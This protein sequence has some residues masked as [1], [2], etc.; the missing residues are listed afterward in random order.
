MKVFITGA[1]SGVGRALAEELVK[2]G[3]QVWGVARRGNLLAGIQQ[4]LN[5]GNFFYTQCDILSELDVK[6]VVAEM[7][8]RNFL[9]DTVVLNAGAFQE[10]I[11]PHYNH[12]IA[13]HIFA[14]NVYGALIWVDRLV[15]MFVKRGSGQFLAVSSTSAYRPDITSASYPASKVAL[16]MAFRSLRLR[17]QKENVFFKTI[18][19][20]PIATTISSRYTKFPEVQKKFFFVLTPKQA[21]RSLIKAMEG[22]KLEYYFPFS[23]LLFSV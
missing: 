23:S 15:A 4:E 1:S 11:S 10:D 17:Y 20:G 6:R 12:K 7:E 8:R 16:S 19:F 21:A 3:H 22:R 13:E 5:S 2:S 9:P 18:H 14:T